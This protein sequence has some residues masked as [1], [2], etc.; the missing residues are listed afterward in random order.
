MAIDKDIEEDTATNIQHFIIEFGYPTVGFAACFAWE[1]PT[2][3]KVIL[4]LILIR[5][6]SSWAERLAIQGQIQASY[7]KLR[8]EITGED[9]GRAPAFYDPNATTPRVFVNVIVPLFGWAMCALAGWALALP[10]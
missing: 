3:P 8:T 10:F 4:M 9:P 7:R 1:A 2:A 5:T 6:A